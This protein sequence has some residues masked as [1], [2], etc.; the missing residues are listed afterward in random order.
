MVMARA[1]EPLSKLATVASPWPWDIRP[2]LVHIARAY[3]DPYRERLRELLANELKESCGMLDSVLWDI[4]EFDF[5]D[6]KDG[7]ERIATSGPED[8]DGTQGQSGSNQRKPL[9]HRFHLAR[10]IATLWNEDKP[11][12]R[13]NCS[14]PSPWR[15]RIDLAWIHPSAERNSPINSRRPQKSWKNLRLTPWVNS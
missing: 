7:V 5:R 14:W 11:L 12:T 9:N 1:W 10:Q 3:P 6:L 4:W 2:A 13:A 8:F 15:G